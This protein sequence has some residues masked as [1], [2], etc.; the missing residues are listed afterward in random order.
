MHLSKNPYGQFCERVILP[1]GDLMTGQSVM[2]Q[3]EFHR[4]AQWWPRERLETFQLEALRR[5]IATAIRDVPFYRDLYTEHGISAESIR[6]LDDVRRLPMV[7]KDLLRD[8]Y[9]EKCTRPTG[10]RTQ[11]FFTSGS[12][13]RPFAVKVDSFDLSVARALMFLRAELSGWTIGQPYLQTGMSLERGFVRAAKDTLLR[14]DYVSAFDLSDDTLD[15]YLR[16]LRTGRLRYVMGYAASLYL[17]AERAQKSGLAIPLAGAVSWGD[18]LFPHYRRAIESAFQCRVT[19]TY[20]CG[21]GIQV[22]AQCKQGDGRYHIFMPHVLVEILRDG[23]PVEAGEMGEIVVT[24]LHAGAMPLIRYRVGDIGRA[25]GE[26]LCHCGRKL[27]SLQSVEGRAT[28]IV[29]TPNGGRLIVHFFTGIFEYVRSIDTFQV[30][31][32]DPSGI[33]IKI[34]PKGR[35]DEQ[36]WIRLR[37]EILRRGD[38]DLDVRLEIVESIPLEKSNKRRFVISEVYAANVRAER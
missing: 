13:G 7:N 24:R 38:P 17:L 6:S 21:E 27:A 8:A 35:F 22:A 15:R 9:P 29:T 20:G 26:D 37:D 18:N 5:T 19:D 10:L 25:E 31:Q 4:E 23:Q 32:S 30:V 28:D 33:L 2:K 12:T 14:C 16:K 3:L 1:I 36:E 34:V 11:E